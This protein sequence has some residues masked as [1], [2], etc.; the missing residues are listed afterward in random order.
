MC[1]RKTPISV[2]A[3]YREIGEFWDEHDLT[4]YWEQTHE[5]EMDVD[6]V[7]S[8]EASSR[9]KDVVKSRHDGSR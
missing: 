6:I 4:D 7:S 9:T 2:A 1:R 5:V 8:A 3:S